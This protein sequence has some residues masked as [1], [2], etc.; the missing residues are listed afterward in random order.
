L[1][2]ISCSESNV[3]QSGLHMGVRDIT[4]PY[5]YQIVQ[6]HNLMLRLYIFEGFSVLF[7]YHRLAAL[8]GFCGGCLGFVM[9]LSGSDQK[10]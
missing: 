9:L 8:L 3:L 10:D 6:D 4:V 2:I 5:Y 1:S 7:K